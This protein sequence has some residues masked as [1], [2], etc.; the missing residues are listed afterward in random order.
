MSLPRFATGECA[1]SGLYVFGAGTVSWLALYWGGMHP[2]LALVPIMPF[3]PHAARDPGFFADALP[4]AKDTL[5]RFDVWS[6]HPVQVTLFFFGLVNAGVPFGALEE[7]TWGLPLAVLAGRPI[8]VVIGVGIGLLA[9]LHLPARVGWREL[10]VGAFI[11]ASGF[12][13]GLFFCTALLPPGQLRSELSMGVLLCLVA[14]PL[15][16]AGARVM[17]VGRFAAAD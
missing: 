6:R 12:S 1:V 2:A 8:G 13:V 7:G 3:L 15:A 4:G 14:A 5:S 10:M 17:R 9:G 16:M 11:A